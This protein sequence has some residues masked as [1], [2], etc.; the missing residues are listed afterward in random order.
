MVQGSPLMLNRTVFRISGMDCAS[1]EQLIRM[2]LSGQEKIR[3]LTFDV[4]S[5]TLT[6]THAGDWEPIHQV[7]AA[8]D[9]GCVH[10]ETR[11][12]GLD[13]DTP[14]EPA[15]ER[16]LLVQ[17]LIINAFFFVLESLTGYLSG[18][19][20]LLADGLD[21]LADSLVYSLAL[22]A[23][24]SS[25]ARKRNVAVVAGILQAILAVLG[26]LESLRRFFWPQEAPETVS[27]VFVS[28]LALAGNAWCLY[29]LQ[30]SKS[31]EAHMKASM[32]FTSNDVVVNLWVMAAGALVFVTGSPIPDLVVGA[33]VF[34]I[35]AKGAVSIFRLR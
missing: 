24:G 3:A 4:P 20:G 8:L 7:L 27:M 28:L 14:T 29:L 33:L 23:V 13:Q 9:L 6:V 10:L 18:S 30:R 11:S 1:E 19:M 5:R 31:R 16:R 2:K 15:S 34:L 21:M 25:M 35:V 17:V 32:I 12:M 26:L 22:L